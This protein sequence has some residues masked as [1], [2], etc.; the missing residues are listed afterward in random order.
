[1]PDHPR[2][3]DGA[4]EADATYQ[5]SDIYIVT[6]KIKDLQGTARSYFMD[7]DKAEEQAKKIRFAFADCFKQ[8]DFNVNIKVLDF[9][10]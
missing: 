8:A 5:S 1:M 4:T 10:G 3:L 9:G 7:K 6:W 2:I